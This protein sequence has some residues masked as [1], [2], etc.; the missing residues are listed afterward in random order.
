MEYEQRRR[1]SWVEKEARVAEKSRD[2]FQSGVVTGMLGMALAAFTKGKLSLGGKPAKPC[3]H[4]ASL[5]QFYRGK[6]ELPEIAAPGE[7]LRS[8]GH[9]AA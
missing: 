5:A 8:A 7:T 1:A 4:L 9:I 6:I 2:G 3:E